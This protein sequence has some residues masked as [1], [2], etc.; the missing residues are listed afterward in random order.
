M[1]NKIGWVTPY[2]SCLDTLKGTDQ[3]MKNCLKSAALTW[4]KANMDVLVVEWLGEGE[5]THLADVDLP[6]FE[7]HSDDIIYPLSRCHNIGFDVLA[8]DYPYLGWI[9]GDT[10]VPEDYEDRLAPYMAQGWDAI[11][12][13][14]YCIHHYSDQTV[15]H[16][17]YLRYGDVSGVGVAWIYKTSALAGVSLWD[18]EIISGDDTMNCNGLLVDD[19]WIDMLRRNYSDDYLE[20]L[21]T[22]RDGWQAAIKSFTYLH[23]TSLTSLPQGSLGSRNFTVPHPFMLEF[24]PTKDLVLPSKRELYRWSDQAPEELIKGVR[25]RVLKRN[26]DQGEGLCLE[27]L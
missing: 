15:V 5:S 17:T 26:I 12:G 8:P 25:D 18:M 10:T 23:D 4:E 9:D 13:M 11:H 20:T 22:W 7:V 3:I 1:S 19:G 16:K 21:D 24:A 2:F 14:E 27:N 6:T